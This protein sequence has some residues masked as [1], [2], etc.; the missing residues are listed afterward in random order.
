MWSD[1]TDDAHTEVRLKYQL[2]VRPGTETIQVRAISFFGAEL[3]GVRARLGRSWHPVRMDRTGPSLQQAGIPVPSDLRGGGEVEMEISY[4]VTRNARLGDA[5]DIALPVLL[6]DGT[7]AGSPE[8]FFTAEALIP[9]GYTIVESFPTVPRTSVV[10][11]EDRRYG[12]QLQ[13][14]PSLVRWRGQVGQAPLI[15]FERIV[16]AVAVGTI[17]LVGLLLM[18]RMR[19][20]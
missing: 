3:D 7:P 20:A 16:D 10:V 19:R 17:L 2:R 5:F 1:L 9:A 4:R 8:D 15:N 13:V 12:L 18:Q 6:V 11:G 14:I